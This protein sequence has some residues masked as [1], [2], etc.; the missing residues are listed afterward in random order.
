[1]K[2]IIVFTFLLAMIAGSFNASAKV[3]KK[4]VIGDWKYEAPTAPYGFEKGTF[5]F[6]DK[7][8]KLE[9]K[10]ILLDG[11][12]FQLE[13]VKLEKDVLT[14]SL[15]VEGGYVMANFKIDGDSLSGA[16]SSPDGDLKVTAQKEKKA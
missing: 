1:M 2:K 16:V 4:D 12:S 9:G 13:S 5:A 8:G 7:D 3:K 15:Y 6:S 10:L 14:F 11:S